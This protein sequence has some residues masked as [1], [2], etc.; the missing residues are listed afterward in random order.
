MLAEE[1]LGLSI[2]QKDL[3]GFDVLLHAATAL[4]LL[5]VYWR[6]WWSMA[7][8]PMRGDGTNFKLLLAIIVATVPAAIVGVFFHDVIAEQFRSIESV[9]FALIGTGI[10]LLLSHFGSSKIT[11]E[12]VGFPRSLVIGCA[13][14]LALI[15]GIS[16]SGI[17]IAS[18]QLMGIRRSDAL[19]FSF[20]IAFPAIVGA[21]VLMGI[22]MWQGVVILPSTN[23]ALTGFSVSFIASTIAIIFLR[24][25]V[26][27]HSLAWFAAYLI[28]VGIALLVL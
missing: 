21:S 16:R 25:F 2:P 5:L 20:L 8:S 1:F 22:Q 26:A 6:R 7:L 18:G 3:L 10:V 15:P 27:R 19:D 28:P 23:V 12:R 4:A 17:T 13:Q 24:K 14:A 11:L 9:A